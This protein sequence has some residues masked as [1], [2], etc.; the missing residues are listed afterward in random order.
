M[1]YNYSAA[2]F[3]V[4]LPCPMKGAFGRLANQITIRFEKETGERVSFLPLSAMDPEIIQDL[5]S[6]EDPDDFPAVMMIPGMGFPCTERFKKK[7]RDAGCFESILEQTNPT[8]QKYGFYDPRGCYDVVGMNPIAF[9]CDRTYY[10]E[11]TPPR[12]WETLLHDAQYQRM[13]GM[14]GRETTGFQD[15][16]VM[17]AYHLYGE[18]GVRALAKTAR[19]CLLPAEMVRMAGSRRD[20]AP[21]I[22]ILNFAMAKAAGQK[23]SHTE[24]IWPEEGVYAGPMLMLTRKT[25]SEK[26]RALAKQ[27][28]GTETAAAF[29][30]GGFYSAADPEPLGPGEIFWFGWDFLENNDMPALS[31]RLSRLMMENCSLIPVGQTLKERCA[32]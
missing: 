15:F 12:S 27:I 22:G 9:F 14:P 1:K 7:F 11:L 26:A 21:P 20:I 10:Q 18:E 4:L 24:F 16:P 31:A 13:V 28:V 3:M 17:A 25:A 5:M 2:D 32:L 6:I 30:V 8:F 23:N 29:R 19:S